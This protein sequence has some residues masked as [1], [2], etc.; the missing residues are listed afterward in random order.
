MA[1][2]YLRLK[3][4]DP[5]LEWLPAAG[6]YTPGRSPRQ[7]A[8]VPQRTCWR[9]RATSKRTPAERNNALRAH[10]VMRTQLLTLLAEDARVLELF[11][12]ALRRRLLS[13]P[14]DF[15]S[16]GELPLSVTRLFCG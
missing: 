15:A 10:A 2:R 14:P 13:C 3:Q 4:C 5:S 7:P 16:L 6:E 11:G 1:I 8:A 12:P 9:G